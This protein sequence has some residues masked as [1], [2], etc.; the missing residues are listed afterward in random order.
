M[1]L[2]YIKARGEMASSEVIR[3][4]Q[5]IQDRRGLSGYFI[6]PLAGTELFYKVY[7]P[8]QF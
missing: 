1:T 5:D 4:L 6:C 8:G 3:K 7:T 2:G